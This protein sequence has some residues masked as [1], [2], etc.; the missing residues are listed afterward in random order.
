M[1]TA[2]DIV[3]RLVLQVVE[4]GYSREQADS[5]AA[6]MYS[7]EWWEPRFG[8]DSLEACMD[9][10][11]SILSHNAKTHAEARSEY[12]VQADV[13]FCSWAWDQAEERWLTGC[14]Y[15]FAERRPNHSDCTGEY[16]PFPF[17]PYCGNRIPK[18]NAS[19]K[20]RLVGR[21]ACGKDATP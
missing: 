14:G 18:P 8:C 10:L 17:C 9:E 2:S 5:N 6:Q 15:G 7:G 13:R 19:G 11:E 1:T 21:I 4:A 20:P 16:T 12:S 3:V